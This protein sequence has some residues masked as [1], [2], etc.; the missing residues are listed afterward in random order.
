[1]PAVQ[2]ITV[3]PIKS[4]DGHE[5]QTSS[6]LSNGALVGDRQYALV[7][8]W[9]KYVNGKNCPEIH[10]IRAQYSDDLQ[11]VTLSFEDN[12]ETFSLT[13]DQE[14]LANWCSEVLGRS[15]RLIANAD[16]GFPDDSESPG[17]TLVSV[18]TIRK[19][20]EW[21]EELNLD[22]VRRRF[23]FNVE[24]DDATA[25]WEDRL[26]PESQK[27]RRF[28]IGDL[29]W[30]GSGI[31]KRCVVPTRDSQSGDVTANFA[32]QFMRLRE[33]VLPEWAPKERF[34]TF[35]RLGVNTRLDSNGE[36]LATSVGDQVEV[37]Q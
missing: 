21:F 10:R 27:V 1:M 4:L 11:T 13:S 26:V 14:R 30:Q 12:I 31:C 18:G 28:R 35:Y 33:E 8:G 17:L 5:L 6:V 2:R 29:V 7:D 19:M 37:I 9:T 36:N 15:C 20:T 34:D 32:R 3:Y 25:F 22:E 16:G 23:R 24:V